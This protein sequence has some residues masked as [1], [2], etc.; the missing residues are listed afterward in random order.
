MLN[1]Y[2]RGEG[3]PTWRRASALRDAFAALKRCATTVL[4]VACLCLCLVTLHAAA[5]A[6]IVSTSPSITETL[7]AMGLGDRVVGVSTYCRYPAIVKTLPKVG[8]FLRP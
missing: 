1:R 8:T 7:F 5:P 2:Q 4:L 3:L 6:R